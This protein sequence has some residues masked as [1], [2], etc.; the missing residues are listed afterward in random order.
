MLFR[1]KWDNYRSR[2]LYEKI[3]ACIRIWRPWL[4]WN[5][6]PEIRETDIADPCHRSLTHQC[7]LLSSAIKHNWVVVDNSTVT[8]VFVLARLYHQEMTGGSTF[9]SYISS[10]N[11]AKVRMSDV[12]KLAVRALKIT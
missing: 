5:D 8:T 2:S 6:R 3:V 7:L 9:H 12:R 1:E 10:I 4:V 11:L